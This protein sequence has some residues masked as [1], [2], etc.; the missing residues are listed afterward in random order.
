MKR[1]FL[2]TLLLTAVLY[3]WAEETTTV[4]AP[5]VSNLEVMADTNRIILTWKDASD[6]IA[7]YRI[8]RSITP[9]DND[10]ETDATLVAEVA[11]NIELFGYYPQDTGSYYFAVL[12]VD[13]DGREY[14]LY[15][16]YRNITNDAISIVQVASLQERATH[17][18]DISA[19][20][21]GEVVYISYKSSLPERAVMVYRSSDPIVDKNG[22]RSASL[23]TS[24]SSSQGS[25]TDFPLPG[26]EYY[27]AIVDK[28][29]VE[30]DEVELEPGEN[31]TTDAAL[32]ALSDTTQQNEGF[33]NV[34]IRPLP[35]LTLPKSV[36]TGESLADPDKYALPT[37]TPL[38]KDTETAV[39]NLINELGPAPSQS[40]PQAQM[41][42]IDKSPGDNPE[43]VLLSNII[44]GSFADAEWDAA[45]KELGNFL[46]VHRSKT[47]EARAH[48]YMGQVYYFQGQFGKALYEFLFSRE[49]YRQ[50]SNNWIDAT[51]YALT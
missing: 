11:S 42:A 32:V 14:K 43:G 41:L 48:F 23:V 47:V 12:A 1:L 5:F 33:R 44:K 31:A 8:Y 20:V 18:S 3:S 34:R 37:Y 9:F 38:A 24:L 19:R 36:K 28:E 51:F 50:E 10:K 17:I 26:L 30:S 45:E 49:T 40:T 16:P 13:A 4:Y 27:Y 35:Y 15:I 29:L 39:Q 7:F 21:A 25:I 6:P 2:F 22:L 46:A